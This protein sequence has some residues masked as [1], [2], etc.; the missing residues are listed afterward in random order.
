MDARQNGSEAAPPAMCRGM[1][2]SFCAPVHNAWSLL[3]T[4][5]CFQPQEKPDGGGDLPGFSQVL[6]DRLGTALCTLCNEMCERPP[7]PLTSIL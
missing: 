4:V 3:D 1:K 7:D 5:K 2:E 6:Q